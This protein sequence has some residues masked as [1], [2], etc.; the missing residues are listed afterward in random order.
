MK[1]V[2]WGSMPPEK[3]QKRLARK[4]VRDGDLPKGTEIEFVP[5]TEETIKAASEKRSK[6]GGVDGG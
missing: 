3:D 4:I 1:I 6:R 2:C 5:V